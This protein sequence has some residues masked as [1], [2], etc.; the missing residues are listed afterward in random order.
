MP[1]PVTSQNA[2]HYDQ[3][4]TAFSVAYSQTA[5]GFVADKVF[6][7]VPVSNASDVYAT[8]ARGNFFRD[9]VQVRPMG[10]RAPVQGVKPAWASYTI[11]EEAL[12]ATIDDRERANQ[13][14]P[15]NSERAKTR[16]LMDQH[17]I[18]RDR[19]WAAAY[20]KTGV[21]GADVIGHATTA[22]ATQEIFW[23]LSTGVPIQAVR[24]RKRAIKMATGREPNVLVLG[25]DVEMALLDNAEVI[26]RI[27]GGASQSDPALVDLQ[28]L[29]TAFGLRVVTATAIWN[30]AVEDATESMAAIL[31]PKSALLAYAAPNAAIDEPS[32]GYTFAW[33]G[34]LG[35]SADGVSVA[36]WREE[37]NHSDFIEARTAHTCKLVAA[38]LG[39][40]FSAIVQ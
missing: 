33:T 2:F 9:D 23:N 31:T 21:W 20:F 36:R 22:N 7:S 17:L 28:T 1:T 6:P 5:E 15:I 3:P 40:F 8:W 38:D 16:M 12:A 32:A 19:K 27:S 29:S 24:R 34:L 39:L 26:A 37:P 30:S 18:H 14:A 10:G 25:S 11:E 13:T 4:L 35:G